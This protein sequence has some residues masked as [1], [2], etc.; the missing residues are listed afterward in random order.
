MGEIADVMLERSRK[1]GEKDLERSVIGLLCASLF[2]S[3]GRQQSSAILRTVKAEGNEEVITQDEIMA[4]VS[5]FNHAR[6]RTWYVEAS[7]PVDE[8]HDVGRIRDNLQ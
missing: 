1:A 2:L 6:Q 4:Q 7:R 5:H 8:G 3:C